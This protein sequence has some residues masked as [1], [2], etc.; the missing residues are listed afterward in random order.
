MHGARASGGAQ[1]P[2]GEQV[3]PRRRRRAALTTASRRRR[4]RRCS[5]RAA[6]SRSSSATTR[7]T[8]RSSSPRRAAARVEEF[9]WYCE[10]LCENSGRERTG[11][12]AYAVGWTQHTVGVQYIR[13]AAIVQLLLGNI[14][15]PGGGDHGAA[16]ARV[17]PGLDRHPDALQHPPGL[18][19]R[20]RTS[21]TRRTSQAYIDEHTAPG[22]LVGQAR[23]VHRL[24]AEGVVGRGRDARRTTSASRYL[25]RIDDD[26]SNYWTVAADAEG[27]R[28][29]LH[30]RRREPGR[31]LGERQAR[32]GSR[33][34]SSTG[35]SSATS[36]RSR[37]RRSGTTAPRSSRAS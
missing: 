22:G 10:K 2:K 25:P 35:S 3:G 33:S 5:I 6:S 36:S 23:H 17:D 19:G 26:N 24:A 31:R 34:R 4:T 13:A 28:Q 16:R 14:G 21:T 1:P 9:L 29:G 8:R 20:C 30:R 27:Q 18:P 11:A 15:R 32:T 12:F 7:A 37:R